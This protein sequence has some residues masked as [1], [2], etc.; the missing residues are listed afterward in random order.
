ML[1]PLCQNEYS[2]RDTFSFVRDR[3]SA[4]NGKYG[5]AIFNVWSLFMCIPVDE[6]YNTNT[7]KGFNYSDMFCE[8]FKKLFKRIFDICC[9]R[10]TIRLNYKL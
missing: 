9:K 2:V 5:M 7:S 6:A 10:N 8:D 3:V 1:S 4:E